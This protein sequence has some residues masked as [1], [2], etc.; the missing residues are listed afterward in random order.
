M[1]W[2]HLSGR[3]A[4]DGAVQRQ[5]L[6]LYMRLARDHTFPPRK[7]RNAAAPVRGILKSN[8]LHKH[9]TVLPA[10]VVL[11]FLFDTYDPEWRERDGNVITDVLAMRCASLPFR[12]G[13]PQT[14]PLALTWAHLDRTLRGRAAG[15]A[16]EVSRTAASASSCA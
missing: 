3:R 15:T 4:S 13:R 12:D 14:R 9:K 2:E 1:V 5:P 10:V 16:D 8:W 7:V 6:A 11:T